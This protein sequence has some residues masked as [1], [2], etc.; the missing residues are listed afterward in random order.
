MLLTGSKAV[1]Y[2]VQYH[3]KRVRVFSEDV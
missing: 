2:N 1:M 3:Y